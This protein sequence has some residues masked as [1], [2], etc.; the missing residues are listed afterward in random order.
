MKI[1]DKSFFWLFLIAYTL[2]FVIIMNCSNLINKRIAQLEKS[3]YDGSYENLAWIE[4]SCDACMENAEY[5]EYGWISS[6]DGCSADEMMRHYDM[7]EDV[8]EHLYDREVTIYAYVSAHASGEI[9]ESSKCAVFSYG[10]DLP[11]LLTKGR[12]FTQEDFEEQKRVALVSENMIGNLQQKGKNYY[13][14]I[15]NEEYQVVGIYEPADYGSDLYFAYF[16][17]KEE[18]YKNFCKNLAEDLF[19]WGQ[20]TLYVGMKNGD[21]YQNVSNI[22]D[23]LNTIDGV[24]FIAHTRDSSGVSADE[25]TKLL[26]LIYGLLLLLCIV[27]YIQV[28]NLFVQKRKRDYIVYRTCGCDNRMIARKLFA[29]MLPMFFGSFVA[30]FILNSLYNVFI[31]NRTWY[32]ISFAGIAF[33]LASAMILAYMSIF[34]IMMKIRKINLV[35]GIMEI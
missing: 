31:S 5:N 2:L 19:P 11:V 33:L 16:P 9:G 34:I 25:K 23:D 10:D 14:S 3:L 13:I 12:N 35:E 6:I 15:E 26:S 4:V 30:I 28:I 21:I 1:R 29:E 27:I 22:A 17:E 7:A 32:H 18:Y 24:T 20:Y 8:V